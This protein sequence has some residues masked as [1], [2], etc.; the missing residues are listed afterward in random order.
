MSPLQN[1]G[2]NVTA[3]G[4]A[5]GSI[6]LSLEGGFPP[7]VFSWSNGSTTEDL[8]GL[9][10]GPYVISITD[11]GGCVVRD[12]IFLSDPVNTFI[13]NVAAEGEYSGIKIPNGFTPNG[14][15]FNDTWRISGL[16]ATLERNEVLVFDVRGKLV[17]RMQ[18]YRAQWDG[19]DLNGNALPAGD[20]FWVFRTPNAAGVIKGNVNLRR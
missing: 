5:D 14:D 2:Y 10:S 15:G 3:P 13:G 6:D 4:A 17:Y 8:E 19:R 7:F 16:S 18:N 9:N 12:S 11:S 20:Y 1:K